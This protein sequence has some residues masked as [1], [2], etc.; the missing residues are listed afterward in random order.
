[1]KK[2]R[3]KQSKC[4]YEY[5]F[6]KLGNMKI[7]NCTPYPIKY[8]GYKTFTL[9]PS[10]YKLPVHMSLTQLDSCFYTST[11]QPTKAGYSELEEIRFI[12]GSDVIILGTALAAQAYRGIVKL[13][14]I[15]EQTG[16]TLL[17]KFI[18]GPIL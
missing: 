18:V 7:L 1:M 3:K 5:H 17:N 16:Y 2:K 11:V 13:K 6:D 12:Y 14:V 8:A 10:G 4:Y 15:D 9:A